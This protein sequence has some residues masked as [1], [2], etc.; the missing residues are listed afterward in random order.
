MPTLQVTELLSN[1][2]GHCNTLPT[3]LHLCTSGCHVQSYCSVAHQSL[4]YASHTSACR[5]I[6]TTQ[7]NFSSAEAA[8]RSSNPSI[9]E[10]GHGR[11]WDLEETRDYV[12]ARMGIVN[13]LGRVNNRISEATRL[14][15]LQDLIQL[16]RTDP[17]GLREEIP[18][19]LLRL[20][21]DQ[22]C[23]DFIVWWTRAGKALYRGWDGNEETRPFADVRDADVFESLESCF[24][25]VEEGSTQHLLDVLLIKVRLLLDARQLLRLPQSPQA[26][27]AEIQVLSHITAAR[28]STI[29]PEVA[30]R[31]TEQIKTLYRAVEER[32]EFFWDIFLAHDAKTLQEAEDLKFPFATGTRQEALLMLRKHLPPW[33]DTPGAFDVV[34]GGR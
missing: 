23:Y 21:Q 13:S 9:F 2:C 30:D 25:V 15:H 17:I 31:L 10:T 1:R 4:D 26:P 6:V 3:T 14:M 5:A 22:E 29:T 11:F 7:H 18:D 8:L 28:H 34:R 12:D 24:G 27:D 20:G 32:N 33:K 19:V 16:C